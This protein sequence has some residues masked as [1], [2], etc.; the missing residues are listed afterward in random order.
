MAWLQLHSPRGVSEF[1]REI[2]VVGQFEFYSKVLV[3]TSDKPTM[4]EN[5][6]VKLNHHRI[7]ISEFEFDVSSTRVM[8]GDKF[9]AMNAATQEPDQLTTNH[10]FKAAYED[11][12][13]SAS[14]EVY[15][16]KWCVLGDSSVLNLVDDSF[17][18]GERNIFGFPLV[19]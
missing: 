11:G 4:T 14:V 3:R 18:F 7:K 2:R 10:V 16:D 9:N 1:Y 19:K 12:I 17:V 5:R 6:T 15:G 8:L 13:P